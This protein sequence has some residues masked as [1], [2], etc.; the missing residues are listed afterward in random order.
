MIYQFIFESLIL[1]IL[2]VVIYIS[3]IKCHTTQCFKPDSVNAKQSIL[4]ILC[5]VIAHSKTNYPAF[6]HFA[7][8]INSLAGIEFLNYYSVGFHAV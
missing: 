5:P 1:L 2:Q 8:V 3:N 6:I 7:T 4:H